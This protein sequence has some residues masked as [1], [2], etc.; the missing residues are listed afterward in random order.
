MS[1]TVRTRAK[2]VPTDSMR[3]TAL[4]AGALYLTTFASSIPAAFVFIDPV[5]ANADF[6]TRLSGVDT[7]LLWGGFLDL[8]NALACIGTAVVLFPV[9][10]R[11]SEAAALGFVTTR[12]FEA[13][14]IVIG[15]VSLLSVV[16][17]RQNLVGATGADLTSLMTTGDALV[18]V[19]NWTFLI[20]PVFMAALNALLLG[21][22]M[23]RSGL[24][25]RAIPLMGLVGAPLLLASGTAAFFGIHSLTS[26][27]HIVAVAP[28]AFWEL[29]LGLYLVVKGF[30][31]SG[32]TS[33]GVP[34]V[35]VRAA[36]SVA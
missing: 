2:R 25:P 16:T 20:G 23:Y 22:L 8:I 18:A 34:P 36:A 35:P 10:K 28:V 6:M 30:K 15:I 32:I 19:R 5:L 12:M 11:W 31:P 13:A 1:T 17:L 9:V 21:S 3:R 14:V 24:V 33:D 26:A 29:S 27:T 7:P 4:L